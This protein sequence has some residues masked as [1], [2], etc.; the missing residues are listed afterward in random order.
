MRVTL[1]GNSKPEEGEPGMNTSEI[2]VSL[3]LKKGWLNERRLQ[4]MALLILGI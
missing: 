1:F 2:A 4:W 3:L